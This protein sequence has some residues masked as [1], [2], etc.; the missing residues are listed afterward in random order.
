[1]KKYF[2]IFMLLFI[3]A[4]IVS[5][6]DEEIY[7]SPSKDG[8]N[9]I[10]ITL[11]IPVDNGKTRG[12][13][14]GPDEAPIQGESEIEDIY[15]LAFDKVTQK[16]LGKFQSTFTNGV[17]AANVNLE[18]DE[19]KELTIVVLTNLK[20]LENGNDIIS[21]MNALEKGAKTKEEVL[22]SL[23]YTFNSAWVLTDRSLPMWGE[24]NITPVRNSVATGEVNLYRSVSKINVVV[25]NGK[26][27]QENG[28][29]VF[30]LKSVR[31]YYARTSGLVGSLYAPEYNNEGSNTI[32]TPSI[33]ENVSYF[34][35]YNE[36]IENNL[37]F[38]ESKDNGSYAIE[39]KIYVPESNHEDTEEP[40]CLV[41]GGYYMGS[42][43]ESF[44]RVDFKQGNKGS[45]FYNAIRNH[46][47]TFNINNVTRPGT[48][49]PDPA[50]DHV[51]VGMDV[52]IKEWTT[53]WMRGIGGQYTLEVSTG[54]F[55]LAGNTQ[56]D[57]ILKGELTVTT[58]HNE[59][60]TIESQ[61]GSWFTTEETSTGVIIKANQ[62]NG[63]ERRGSFI[64]RSGNLQKE[65][66]V[67]QRGKGTANSYIASDNGKH[68]EQDLIVTVKGNGEVGLVADGTALEEKDPYISADKIGDVQII[69]E[70]SNGLVKIVQ[71]NG[72]AKLDKESGTIKYTVDL[73]KT[74]A[75]IEASNTLNSQSYKGGNALIGAFGKNSD[76]SINYNDLLWTWHIWV[77]PDIDTDKDGFI[78]D[79]ELLA[80]DQ[81]WVTG[82]TFMDRNMGALGN[83]PGLSSLGL[84]Y[85]WGRKDPFI[86]AA[87][88]S[89]EQSN[90]RMSTHLP[91]ESKGY[92]WKSSSGDMSIDQTVKAPTTLINGIIDG[93]DYAL[94]WGTASGLKGETYAGNKTIY[95]P[96]PFGY[97]VPNVAA[98]VF[99]GNA[100]ANI[101]QSDSEKSNWYTNNEFWPYKSDDY[102]DSDKKWI[103]YNQ[104]TGKNSYGF[105]LRYGS[106]DQAPDVKYYTSDTN[107]KQDKS[108]TKNS[109]TWLPL[110]GVY[111]ASITKGTD[112]VLANVDN[113]NSLLVNSIMW[114]NSS[115]LDDR[116]A[117]LFLHG[118][119]S[120]SS[121]DGNHFHQLNEKGSSRALYAKPEQAGALRCVRDTKVYMGEENA[122]KVPSEI[123]LEANIG[124]T[125]TEELTSL[126]D[127]WEVV[128]PGAMWF[129]MTPDA[130]PVGSKQKITF[131][132]TQINVGRSRTAYIKIK[133]NDQN[134]TVKSIKVT[135]AG[136]NLTDHTVTSSITLTSANNN[137][138]SG[139]IVAIN[140]TWEIVSGQVSWLSISPMKS[141]S[142][143]NGGTSNVTYRTTE[144]NTSNSARSTTLT[145]R[146]GN[147]ATKTITVT[148]KGT[149]TLN[150]STTEMDFD[151]YPG[152]AAQYFNI[153]SNTD[154]EIK[155]NKDWLTVSPNSGSKNYNNISV[156]CSNNSWMG[157]SS[158]QG[159]IT[160]KT[161]DGSIVK[162]IT[163]YQKGSW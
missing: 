56:N 18:E 47:Y 72:K 115:A 162:T 9:S 64:I 65:I 123:N 1:M 132:S 63:G 58:T 97:R 78:S 100:H 112:L 163:V 55:I 124:S 145:V 89:T 127:N 21:Q 24:T 2:Y 52:T 54:G 45:E 159:T 96:C 3:Q 93:T 125:Q 153:T 82:Y 41:V 120:K 148:Q 113:Q 59:G 94:L 139:S 119:Q 75:E 40:M 118:V 161:T 51:V 133:F 91:L 12:L 13:I 140:D 160:I 30:K 79:S 99:K 106:N 136:L 44:Y 11:N 88:V 117:G 84:L 46:I 141:A 102:K 105:W 49:E 87:R 143:S 27:R 66:T 68:I 5:C 134:G 25:N 20:G 128:D 37:L 19:F 149:Y 154:W 71:E 147:G 15:V 34:P 43:Q 57:G 4:A 138:Q 29:E 86:G 23:Q 116:P 90:N 42:D 80:T 109:M 114:T 151:R 150:V 16:Y 53:E 142:I 10:K 130:G 77:C 28:T 92:Y 111:D 17:L 39:N 85:Q 146:F 83:Q 110:S 76:G 121:S 50:L 62:N 108:S 38:T 103:T 98:V 137:S 60:W 107:N 35:R 129:V 6:T 61:S 156:K 157:A 31:V 8:S 95:D 122:I 81:E 152:N 144:A 155:A 104:V 7:E 73:T 36:G 70:T 32:T 135:Q 74:N 67:R 131:K 48:D 22:K 101:G 126:L 69:W 26:G 33:P 14:Y 158:R